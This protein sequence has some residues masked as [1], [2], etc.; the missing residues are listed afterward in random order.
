MPRPTNS[1]LCPTFASRNL[2]KSFSAIGGCGR[3]GAFV[4]RNCRRRSKATLP[5]TASL[6][7][8]LALIS[9]LADGGIG[10][11]SETAILRAL[12]FADYLETHAKRAYGAGADKATPA[13]KAI[14]AHI[15]DG[16]LKD[17][18]SARDVYRNQW[19][20]LSDRDQVKAG[21]NLLEDFDWL[22]GERRETG[23]RASITYRIN[24]EAQA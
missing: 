17:G 24:P 18:F 13:A 5:N 7:R 12:A 1:P 23:G 15:R 20:D 10:A 3:R 6:S 22:R 19:A 2:H 11:I 21:L 14:L 4:P 9:H 8:A 16:G